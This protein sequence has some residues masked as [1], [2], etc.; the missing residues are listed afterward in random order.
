MNELE[1]QNHFVPTFFWFLH[2]IKSS[3]G[4]CEVFRIGTLR[5]E[6]Q[7]MTSTAQDTFKLF[8]DSFKGGEQLGATYMQLTINIFQCSMVFV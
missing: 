6:T 4:F 7:F 8:V 5:F 1:R 3:L 2:F